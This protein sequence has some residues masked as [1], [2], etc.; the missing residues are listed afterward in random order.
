M[1]IIVGYITNSIAL[2]A[3]SFHMLSDVVALIVG[4]A[5][6]RIARWP[7]RI[8]TYG[9]VRS[10]ILGAMFNAVFLL[11]LC[12]SITIDA[13]K[14]LI[15]PEPIEQPMLLLVVGTAGLLVNILGLFLFHGHAH[16]HSH[17]DKKEGSNNTSGDEA[18]ALFA[19]GDAEDKPDPNENSEAAQDQ[20]NKPHTNIELTTSHGQDKE[21]KRVSSGTQMNM[22]G[23]FLHVLGDALGSVVV[24]VSALV[25]WFSEGN[26]RFYVDPAM[27]IGMVI[28]ILASTI[29]LMKETSLILL[30]TAPSSVD[31]D[32]LKAELEQFD[33]VLGVHEFHLWQLTSNRLVLSA[34]I[35]CHNLREYMTIAAKVK[36]FFHRVGIH[37]TTIQPEFVDLN[38]SKLNPIC[39]LKCSTSECIRDTC[40]GPTTRR[41]RSSKVDFG[42]PSPSSSAALS[43]Q[44]IAVDRPSIAL[45]GASVDASITNANNS[46]GLAMGAQNLETEEDGIIAITITDFERETKI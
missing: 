16:G 40:C 38:E 31:Q 18:L 34:H 9:W 35:T 33:G 32:K 22:K 30:Q 3:D 27:S 6:I 39:N 5:S 45:Y 43:C 1:E 41:S 44:S 7:S 13:L 25:I 37:S 14:R 19:G 15:T 4:F 11:A 10:E 24:I 2:V 42:E 28:I 21:M 29:P 12:F 36:D 8:N 23:V 26:W 17:G 46:S 20:T